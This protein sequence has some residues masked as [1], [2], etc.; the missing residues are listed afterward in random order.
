MVSTGATR[1]LGESEI[2]REKPQSQ[3]RRPLLWVNMLVTIPFMFGCA[4]DDKYP[5]HFQKIPG[6]TNAFRLKVIEPG[7]FDPREHVKTIQVFRRAEGG[8]D[9]SAGQLCWEVVAGPPVR[10][11]GLDEIVAGQVPEGFRQV[12]PLPSETFK[13]VPG[14]WYIISVTMAHPRAWPYVPTPWKAEQQ[15][16]DRE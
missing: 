13:P 10:A 15:A 14:K 4:Y 7:F 11:K 16:A 6:H 12:V 3:V 1:A 9:R 8:Y 2:G 5:S